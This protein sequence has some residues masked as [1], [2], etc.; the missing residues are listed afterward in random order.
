M[1]Q[2][3]RFV[4]QSFRSGLWKIFSVH[5]FLT[6]CSLIVIALVSSV[7]PLAFLWLTQILFFD[8][9]F[10]S[11]E[12]TT[13]KSFITLWSIIEVC[14]FFYQ[15][16]LYNKIQNQRSPPHLTNFERDQLVSYALAN[17]RDVKKTMTKW[18]LDC[19]FSDIDRESILGW[20]AFA[21]YSKNIDELNSDE[22]EE[23]NSFINRIEISHQV[24]PTKLKSER[25]IAHMKHILDP[26][27]VIFRPFAAYF[28]TDTILD[29]FIGRTIFHLKRYQFVQIGDLQFWTYYNSALKQNPQDEKDP[30]VF[31]HGIGAGLLFYQPFISYLHRRFAMNRRLIFISMRCISLR[32][33]K[34]DEIP[35]MTETSDSIKK[36]FDH[37]QIKKAVF[38]GHR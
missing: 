5:P 26:V 30:I 8:F 13:L 38:I 37:Y 17:I 9:S 34:M 16:K 7:I 36:I 18:F 14:F 24:K 10:L 12:S 31:F 19:P 28:V 2:E 35:N 27:R 25:R 11:I 23:V 32:Y 1:A 15:L 20:L 21:F 22:Y 4:V 29:R 33:P 3:I 6:L